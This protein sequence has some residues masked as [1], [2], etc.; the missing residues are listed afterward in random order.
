MLSEEEKYRRKIELL[1][2]ALRFA[3]EMDKADAEGEKE[4]P[5]TQLAQ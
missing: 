3:D 2:R 5:I 4:K 1:K